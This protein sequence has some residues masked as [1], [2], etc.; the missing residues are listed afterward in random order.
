MSRYFHHAALIGALS[1]FPFST[2]SQA[3][4][5]SVD[6]LNTGRF[7]AIRINERLNMMVALSGKQGGSMQVWQAYDCKKPYAEALYRHIVDAEGKPQGRFYGKEFGHYQAPQP[8]PNQDPETLKRICSL[9]EQAVVWEKIQA[10]DRYGATLLIDTANL[11]RVADNL[12]VRVGTDYAAIDFDPPYDA[13]YSFKAETYRY[14]CKTGSSDPLTALDIDDKGYVTDSLEGREIERRK[15]AFTLTPLLEKHFAQLCKLSDLST[16]HALGRFIPATQKPLSASAHPTLQDLSSNPASLL[17]AFPLAPALLNQAKALVHPW[18]TPRF[19]QISWVEKNQS[20]ST[21][22]Q[23][24][25]DNNGFIR[26]LEDYGIWKV[27]RLSIANDTQL[28]FTMSIS[29]HPVR[30]KQL[31][32]T[33]RYPLH[34]GQQY[35]NRAISEGAVDTRSD[36]HRSESCEVS[37]GGDAHQINA[38]FSGNYLRVD[39]KIETDEQPVIVV[40]N[41]WLEDL[42][43]MAPLS[44]KIGDKPL[45]P[46][47]LVDVKIVP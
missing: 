46:I 20:G 16:F 27:Q 13:P 40:H 35:Q 12:I 1:L 37:K 6:P 2:L 15:A 18:A 30:L 25:V 38:A 44:A 5:H 29:S 22:V 45:A 47:T 3:T 7:D 26:K 33:L 8:G 43:I 23:M 31:N 9:P 21:R 28:A 14:N 39:C 41:A 34:I 36:S 19:R 24:V 32:T 42:R 4:S 17:A 10:T 11:K